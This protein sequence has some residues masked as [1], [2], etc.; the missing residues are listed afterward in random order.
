[1]KS[2]KDAMITLSMDKIQIPNSIGKS[3]EAI[4]DF[5]GT[6]TSHKIVLNPK[7]ETIDQQ[8]GTNPGSVS[9]LRES[10]KEIIKSI[11]HLSD[12]A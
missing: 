7:T 9:N 5:G 6:T 3:F 4:L 12:C 1:M 11:V 10:K 2:D 8:P